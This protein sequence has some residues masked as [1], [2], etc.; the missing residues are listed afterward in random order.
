MPFAFRAGPV[1]KQIVEPAH[2]AAH[3]DGGVRHAGPDHVRLP[4]NRVQRQC[5]RKE[6]GVIAHLKRIPQAAPV[7][8]PPGS[9]RRTQVFE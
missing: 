9:P 1:L 8:L 2:G 6:E 5:D 3:Q 4:E 7:I